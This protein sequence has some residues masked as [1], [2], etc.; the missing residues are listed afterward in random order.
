[1]P[2]QSWSKMT[3]LQ[4][5][6][7]PNGTQGES[8]TFGKTPAIILADPQRVQVGREQAGEIL[9]YFAATRAWE[10]P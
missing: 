7:W 10:V 1:M 8:V 6:I 2:Q 5:A 4:D 3:K 9:C